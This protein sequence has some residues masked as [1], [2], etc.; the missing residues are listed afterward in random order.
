[1]RLAERIFRRNDFYV[2]SPFGNRRN[3]VTGRTEYHNGCDYGT[4]RQKWAQYALE[5]GTV[6]NAGRDGTGAIFAWIRY[7]RLGIDLLHYHLDSVNVKTGQA[8]TDKTIIGNTG[9]TG[10]STG[11]HLHLSMRRVGNT[12]YVDPHT[13][14]YA[15]SASSG[16]TATTP[17]TTANYKVITKLQGFI[18]A[19]DATTGRNP[20]ATVN[21]GNYF[22]FNSLGD[23]IN[24]TTKKGQ[25]G[26][27][28]NSKLNKASSSGGNTTNNIGTSIKVGDR[29][30]I[31]SG[32]VYGGLSN[33]RGRNVPSRVVGTTYTVGQIQTNKGVSEALLN[34]IN[35]WVAVS[36]LIK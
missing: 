2:T 7:P 19:V 17:N 36:S 25:P 22:I 26:S 24:V 20:R 8:V 30:K 23:A 1:M 32:A 27:W 34:G 4:N 21:I 16:G 5:S 35:S 33:D 12:T 14:N 28:I 11:I 6:L 15:A 10:N 3:P 13:F 18:T 9:T 29:V 31:R